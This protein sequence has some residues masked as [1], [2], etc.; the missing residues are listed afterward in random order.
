MYLV[1]TVSVIQGFEAALELARTGCRV[2]LAVRN[3][4]RGDEAADKI[5]SLSGNS[6]VE[7]MVL[8]MSK[9]SSVQKFAGDF[10]K[11]N[12][13]LHVL[14]HNAGASSDN[15]QF[16]EDGLEQNMA[17]NYINVVLLTSLLLPVMKMASPMAR[18]VL[19]S[20]S[21]HFQ[22]KREIGLCLAES[23]TP[24]SGWVLYGSSKMNLVAYGKA[25]GRQ[26]ASEQSSVHVCSLDPGFVA[27]PF[28]SKALPFPIS[29]F[30]I[31]AN[32]FAK[33]PA[34]GAH[35]HLYAALCPTPVSN[36]AYLADTL[37]ST[38]SALVRDKKYQDDLMANTLQKLSKAA[39]W[40]DNKWC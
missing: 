21:A 33:S 25:L 15:V 28:Y 40:W 32:W 16:N 14:V 29:A 34:V 13:P 8:D 26:L 36:G 18:I 24:I 5:K 1:L 19:V 38:A 7:V 2:I 39:P 35:T 31:M 12:L 11:K 22:G 20:S 3:N 6:N 23:K 30:A 10:K 27:T 17:L 37:E 4:K 9:V